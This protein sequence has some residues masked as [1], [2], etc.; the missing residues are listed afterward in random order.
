MERVE[1]PQRKHLRLPVTPRTFLFSN[2]LGLEINR[3]EGLWMHLRTSRATETADNK[4]GPG[5]RRTR[6]GKTTRPIQTGIAAIISHVDI[7]RARHSGSSPRR[8]SESERT[9]RRQPNTL[10]LHQAGT[11]PGGTT[12]PRIA[13]ARRRRRTGKRT[14]RVQTNRRQHIRKP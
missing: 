5:N 6:R 9:P 13:H 12:Q 7:P 10:D 14:P 4:Q 1:V 2:T 3:T 11:R 8:T